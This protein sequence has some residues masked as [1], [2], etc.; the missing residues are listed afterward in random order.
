MNR[1]L[2]YAMAAALSLGLL[3]SA[4]LTATGAVKDQS[5]IGADEA[6]PKPGKGPAIPDLGNPQE[7]TLPDENAFPEET[8]EL[9]VPDYPAE[10]AD[11]PPITVIELDE[12]TARRALDAYEK[13]GTK[14]N[15][16]G[17]AD[18]D[19]LEQFVAKTDAGKKLEAEIRAFGFD[20]ISEW[21]AAIT[22]VTV[23]YNTILHDQTADIRSQIASVKADK[24]LTPEKKNRIIA[25][26]GALIPSEHNKDVIQKL[27]KDPVYQAKLGLIENVE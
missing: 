14:Y 21:D 18:Y 24:S 19:S 27:M 7:E 15:D 16:K 25:S 17:L 20:N 3:V 12:D 9:K 11:L 13:V 4:P 22:S 6:L 8:P 26:L 1:D 2:P 23:A 10:F 5:R